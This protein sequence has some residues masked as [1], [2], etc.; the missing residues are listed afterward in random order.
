MSIVIVAVEP[1]L[2]SA[3]LPAAGVMLKLLALAPVVT[4][5][6]VPGHEFAE[7][8]DEE[9]RIELYEPNPVEVLVMSLGKLFVKVNAGAPEDGAY[10]VGIALLKTSLIRACRTA[11]TPESAP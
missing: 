9:P 7:A 1:G 5:W 6:N 3:L 11:F 4:S 8:D 10:P 2:H